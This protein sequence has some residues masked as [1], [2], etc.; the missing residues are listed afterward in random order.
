[1]VVL[2]PDCDK[3]V[4]PVKMP[5]EFT[6]LFE[7]V[8]ARRCLPVESTVDI[9]VRPPLV[10]NLM[11]WNNSRLEAFLHSLS[12]P[13]GKR[14]NPQLRTLADVNKVLWALKNIERKS[15]PEVPA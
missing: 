2:V 11:G 15:K 14:S 9:G 13:L 7:K 1:M 10:M 6:G 8:P 5:V 12:S 4:A 3:G